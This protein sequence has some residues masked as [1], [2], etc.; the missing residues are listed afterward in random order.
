MMPYSPR[1]RVATWPMRRPVF[2]S[3]ANRCGWLSL[4]NPVAISIVGVASI[5]EWPL[6]PGSGTF[7]PLRSG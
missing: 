4:V 6:R 2:L 7:R 3:I 5:A 1:S